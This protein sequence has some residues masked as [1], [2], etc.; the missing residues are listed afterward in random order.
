MD[1][2][3]NAIKLNISDDGKGFDPEKI[4]A[5][6]SLGFSNIF[7]RAHL[8]DGKISI[9]SAPEKGCKLNVHIPL[10]SSQLNKLYE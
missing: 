1:E 7:S 8:F 3:E 6:K 2:L 10:H 5:K 4:K 9:V